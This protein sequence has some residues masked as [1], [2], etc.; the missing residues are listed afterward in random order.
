M[1]KSG[2]TVACAVHQPSSQMIS[3]F[4]N[5]IVIDQ[6][7]I[8]YCGPRKDVLDTFKEAGYISPRFYNIVEFGIPS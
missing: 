4:D 8:L 5:I 2:C 1:S 7:K 6:G 3:D